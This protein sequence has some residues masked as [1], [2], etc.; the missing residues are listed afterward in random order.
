MANPRNV[1]KIEIFE[2]DRL[3]AHI[4]QSGRN[5]L[6][7]PKMPAKTTDRTP[8]NVRPFILP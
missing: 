6:E 7:A 4:A 5:V 8:R 2:E 1:P 3:T